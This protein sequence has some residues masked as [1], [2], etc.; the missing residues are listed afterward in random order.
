MTPLHSDAR[1]IASGQPPRTARRYHR[2]AEVGMARALAV[3]MSLGMLACEA[4]DG[5]DVAPPDVGIAADAA[6]GDGAA[7]DAASLDA[8]TPDAGSS[9]AASR[10]AATADAALRDAASPDVSAPDAAPPEPSGLPRFAFPIQTE[11]R[12]LIRRSP[13]FGVDHDP[14]AY[15]GGERWRC[16]NYEG[17]QFPFCYDQ[18]DGSDFMLSGA[19]ERMDA[20]SARV[21]AAAGGEVVRVEDGNYDRCHASLDSFDVTCDGHPMAANRVHIRH[22]SGWES[23]YLHLKSGS[24]RVAVGDHVRCGDVL[25]LVGSSG[26]SSAPHLHFEVHGPDGALWDPFAGPASQPESLWGEQS[27]GDGLPADACDA[28]WGR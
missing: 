22:A 8:A 14:A 11:D 16:T 19:F 10:D 5:G 15:S 3:V 17:R 7:P 12:A 1:A 6:P 2:R 26:N 28:A 20:G 23:R 4:D 24:V 27:P 25:G 13:I 18:H 21:V 9:D